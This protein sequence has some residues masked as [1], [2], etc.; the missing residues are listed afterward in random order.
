MIGDSCDAIFEDKC[1]IDVP[2]MISETNEA[3]S[4]PPTLGG[5]EDT[6]IFGCKAP[7][8][9]CSGSNQ[10]LLQVAIEFDDFPSDI[11]GFATDFVTASS[12]AVLPFYYTSK[13][14]NKTV[15]H[16]VCVPKSDCAIFV[17]VDEGTDGMTHGKYGV[18]LGNNNNASLD[19]NVGV[20]MSS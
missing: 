12:L 20:K 9:S 8:F 3:A 16:R 2:V 10:A 15:V 14:L 5:G 7:S 13:Y 19:S 1:E 18:L 6:K 11:S 17:I 4:S